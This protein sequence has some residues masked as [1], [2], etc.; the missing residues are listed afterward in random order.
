LN[1]QGWRKPPPVFLSRAGWLVIFSG[2]AWWPAVAA[3]VAPC[4]RDAALSHCAQVGD[5]EQR[6]RC[7]DELV[8]DGGAGAG[9]VDFGRETLPRA[10]HQATGGPNYLDAVVIRVEQRPRGER[11]FLLDNGQ[12]WTELAPGRGRYSEGIPVRIERTTLGGYMLKT[13]RGQATRVRRTQ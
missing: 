12:V 2:L 4:P 8:S 13:D 11:T 6:L 1:D 7:F 3:T 5:A 10:E 9:D